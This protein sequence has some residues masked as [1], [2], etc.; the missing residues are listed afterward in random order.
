PTVVRAM[1]AAASGVQSAAAPVVSGTV[2]M[3]TRLAGQ[4]SPEDTVFVFARPAEGSRMP[5]AILRKQVKDLPLDFRF[6]VSP[7]VAA[8][9]LVVVARISPTGQPTA[10]S[11]DLEGRS[12]AVAAGA[13]AG[14]VEI[15]T[16]LP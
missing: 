4:T 8:S 3:A 10:Q 15:N 2:R 5:L 14:P 7:T 13:I 1:A 16:R 6:E 11:G 12:A 9:R